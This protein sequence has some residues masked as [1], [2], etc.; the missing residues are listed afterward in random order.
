LGPQ[1]F[2]KEHIA[3]KEWSVIENNLRELLK[4]IKTIQSIVKPVNL[5][6]VPE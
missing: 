1:V 3:L 5:D 4:S 2:T 6:S